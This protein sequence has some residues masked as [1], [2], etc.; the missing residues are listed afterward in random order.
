MQSRAIQTRALQV[1]PLSRTRRRTQ[2][3]VVNG[4][5]T[6]RASQATVLGALLTV[7]VAGC[8]SAGTAQSGAAALTPSAAM[9]PSAPVGPS[10][11]GTH[12]LIGTSAIS[13]LE[14]VVGPGTVAGN[15]DGPQ[16]TVITGTR[17]PSGLA[18]WH[19]T[20]AL[21]ARSVAEIQDAVGSG[22]PSRITEILYDPEHWS[23]TPITEQQNVGAATAQAASIAHGAGRQLIVTPAS[24]LADVEAPGESFLQTDD[25]AKVAASA[26][27]V[28]IQAQGL[29]RNSANYAAYVAQAVSQ[30]R[31]ANASVQ[32]YA[33]LS[34][35]P[36][37]GPVTAPE[38]VSDVDLTRSEVLGYWLNIPAP[39]ASCP[40]CAAPDPQIALDLLQSLAR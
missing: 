1:G 27:V 34:T 21:D 7:M 20:F 19:V 9:Q 40:R 15:Q 10:S 13:K 31:S 30:I 24:D 12:W 14:G 39:S 38:L 22:L 3:E 26:N 29:E 8:G 18:G 35:N 11:T 17:I 2:R 4:A 32:I 16:T 37:G 25:L 23:F 28:E 5:M 33:G 6:G 36:S